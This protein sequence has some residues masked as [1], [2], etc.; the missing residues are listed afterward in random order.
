[1]EDRSLGRNVTGR[2]RFANSSKYFKRNWSGGEFVEDE[3]G[4]GIQPYTKCV[5]QVFATKKTTRTQNCDTPLTMYQST[6]GEVARKY[7]C[8]EEKL[9]KN[10]N[11]E[12]PC[13]FCE[14]VEP[15]CRGYYR[16]YDCVRPNE[17][18]CVSYDNGEKIY[19]N[20]VDRYWQPCLNEAQKHELYVRT[21]GDRRSVRW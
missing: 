15:P 10:L 11:S 18:T 21:F 8:G 3:H 9:V 12:P 20:R 6:I 16:K 7:L 5:P 19:R 13:N 14:I 1:M 17:E 4:A 2:C